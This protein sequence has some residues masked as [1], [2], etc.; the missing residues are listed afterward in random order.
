MTDASALNDASTSSIDWICPAERPEAEFDDVVDPE[1]VCDELVEPVEEAG[2]DAVVELELLFAGVVGV[3]ETETV[4]TVTALESN[5][6]ADCAS[7]RPFSV[8]PV[9]SAIIV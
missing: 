4:G 3:A 7:A 6:T 1:L 8:A 5:V 9:W 2:V